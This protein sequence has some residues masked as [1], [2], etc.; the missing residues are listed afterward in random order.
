MFLTPP[1]LRVADT[2]S[3]SPDIADV[4]N[5]ENPKKKIGKILPPPPRVADTPPTSPDIADV[6]NFEKSTKSRGV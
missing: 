6:E 5:F 2:P 3:R 1:P 4:E